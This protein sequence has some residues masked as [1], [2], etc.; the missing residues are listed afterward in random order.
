MK[1]LLILLYSFFLLSSPSVFADD[2]S[3]FQIEG[4]SIGD[5]LL[6]YMTEDEILNKIDDAEIYYYLNEPNKFIEIYI[7]KDLS[8][9]DNLS[10]FIKTE[11]SNQY[12]TNKN[13]KY[14][15]QSIRGMI[16]Y[17]ED[18]DSCIVKRNEIIEDLSQMF[19]DTEKT[20]SVYGSRLEPEPSGDSITDKVAFNFNSGALIYL[21]CQ[22]WEETF[23]IEK[24]WSDTLNIVIKTKEIV[25]W[26]NN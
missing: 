21:S 10:V 13:M 25:S 2:I 23:R 22:D 26:F 11:S 18:F 9:Y 1:K 7:K 19:S 15:I 6:D 16:R 8:M 5:S 12:I 14:A 24:N 17:N 4:I 3:D 20:E